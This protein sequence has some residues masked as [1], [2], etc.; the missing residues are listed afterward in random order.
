MFNS[1][2]KFVAGFTLLIVLGVASLYGASAYAKAATVNLSAAVS[3]SLSK[4]L[5]F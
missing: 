1:L 3:S 2:I 4:L 5:P